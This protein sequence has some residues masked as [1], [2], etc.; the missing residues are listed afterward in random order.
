MERCWC[1]R[2]RFML[3]KSLCGVCDDSCVSLLNGCCVHAAILLLFAV[4][5]VVRP[6]T[7]AWMLV[8]TRGKDGKKLFAM[9]LLRILMYV[10]Y[11]MDGIYDKNFFLRVGSWMNE[12]MYQHQPHQRAHI[13]GPYTFFLHYRRPCDCNRC[14]FRGETLWNYY[15]LMSWH[16][17]AVKLFEKLKREIVERDGTERIVYYILVTPKYSCKSGSISEHEIRTLQWHI[18]AR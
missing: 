15:Y 11:C 9:T 13:S 16:C 2:V 1:T 3:S 6:S 12:W 7:F 5:L 14:D 10:L 18:H 17:E 4:L 8:H